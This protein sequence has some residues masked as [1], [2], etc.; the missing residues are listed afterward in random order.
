MRK[1]PDLS[2]RVGEASFWIV[3]CYNMEAVA[4]V[5]ITSERRTLVGMLSSMTLH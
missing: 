4:E 5:E 2:H 3:D 1:H